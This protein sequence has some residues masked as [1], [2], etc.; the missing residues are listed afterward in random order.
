MKSQSTNSDFFCFVSSLAYIWSAFFFLPFP[1]VWIFHFTAASS[2]I[3][4]SEGVLDMFMSVLLSS[5]TVYVGSE[6]AWVQL[7]LWL[8]P[9]L[10]VPVKSACQLCTAVPTSSWPL[11]W[12]AAVFSG[13]SRTS[14]LVVMHLYFFSKH[15]PNC[16]ICSLRCAFSPVDLFSKSSILYFHTMTHFEVLDKAVLEKKL[17]R[18]LLIPLEY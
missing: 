9:T 11:A 6:E 13:C 3:L 12:I 5:I 10:S 2:R 17:E 15:R 18:A 8:L 4:P 1:E 7:R 14:F 16:F